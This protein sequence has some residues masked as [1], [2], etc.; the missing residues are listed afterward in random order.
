MKNWIFNPF[1]HIAGTKALLA[2]MLGILLTGIL[3]FISGTH[4]DGV[5]DVHFSNEGN[6]YWFLA[7]GFIDLTCIV[8]AFSLLGLMVAGLRFRFI[9]LLG[10]LSMARLPF[11]LVALIALIFPQEKVLDYFL[12]SYLKIGTPV[13]IGNWDIISFIIT[14]L[15][16]LL[17]TIWSVALMYN[18]YRICMN[19][20]GP[21]IVISFIGGLLLAEIFAKI[22]FI[23]FFPSSNLLQ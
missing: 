1:K 6:I 19:I 9:D 14:M 17:V 22:I 21:K 13:T 23:L 7:E 8:L 4:L 12:Y 15:I 2:G 18:A 11:L 10:T 3:C 5:I 20:K 16:T